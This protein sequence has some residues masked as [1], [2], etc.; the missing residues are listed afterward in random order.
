MKKSITVLAVLFLVLAV[1]G[2]AFAAKGLLTGADI[3]DGSLTGADVKSH[4][5]GAGSF[6]ASARSSLRG[7]TGLTGAKGDKGALGLTGAAGGPQGVAGHTGSDGPKGDTGDAG[8]VGP[9]GK[10][11]PSSEYG[12]ATVQ[13]KRGANT[14]TW[15]TYSTALGSP[16]GDTTGGTF[17]MT[18]NAAQAPCEISVQAAALSSTPGSV[19]VYPRVLVHRDGDPDSGSAASLY[20]EYA[21]GSTGAA[22]ATLTKQTKSSSPAYAPLMINIGGS[23]DC[24]IGG[25]AGDVA[26]IVV[27]KGYYNITS[28]FAFLTS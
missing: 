5:L 19:K 8:H 23:A 1:S 2:G 21:D 14:S 15:A 22:P 11:A 27:P 25:P 4:S 20:C 24:G 17:R 26:S 10:D 7:L 16:V 28:T 6:A 18:C 9:A 13:V 3:K 12:A